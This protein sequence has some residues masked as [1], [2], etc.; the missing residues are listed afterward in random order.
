MMKNRLEDLWNSADDGASTP[1]GPL[2]NKNS[3]EFED[4]LDAWFIER[5]NSIEFEILLDKSRDLIRR[6]VAESDVSPS[7][8]RKALRLIRAIDRSRRIAGPTKADRPT[9]R[10]SSERRCFLILTAG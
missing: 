9:D 10:R 2:I 3:S 7:G 1:V 5:R 6:L 4:L 8:R